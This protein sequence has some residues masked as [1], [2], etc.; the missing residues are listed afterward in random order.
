MVKNFL[1][2]WF[3]RRK[4]AKD[5]RKAQR[6]LT[7]CDFSYATQ[8]GIMGFFKNE[9]DLL[10]L[11]AYMHKLQKEGK[12]VH[13]L[14]FTSEKKP[15]H[16]YMPKLSVD[17]VTRKMVNWYNI[18]ASEEVC[19][20]RNKPF[21]V[22]LDLCPDFRKDM[23]YVAATSRA[24]LKVGSYHPQREPYFDLM[25]SLN[26]EYSKD[27]QR[28]IREVEKYLHEIKPREHE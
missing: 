22:L 27:L 5:A 18:P 16:Y 7:N 11:E 12:E 25:L 6:T 21:H 14:L 8:V 19:A 20:F 1:E 3:Y 28:M 2:N 4:L 10:H 13:M 26:Q 15:P 9:E 17:F 24:S 23:L